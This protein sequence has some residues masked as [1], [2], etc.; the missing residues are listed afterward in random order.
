ME[1]SVLTYWDG[2]LRRICLWKT[3]LV[4]S[5][6]GE[7]NC[8]NIQTLISHHLDSHV[9]LFSG[10]MP[11]FARFKNQP[12]WLPCPALSLQCPEDHV[13]VI[14][15]PTE[16]HSDLPQHIL[17]LNHISSQCSHPVQTVFSLAI[18]TSST[19]FHGAMFKCDC[20]SILSA[21]VCLCLS[22]CMYLCMCLSLCVSVCL[23]V[24]IKRQLVEVSSFLLVSGC[25][26]QVIRIGGQNLY[27]VAILPNVT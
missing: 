2:V 15:S 23:C 9:C 19:W 13:M 25:W 3:H 27:S 18:L 21:S 16:S 24:C 5:S 26:I 22:V 12:T 4:R 14:T 1:G 10:L 11:D 6:C 8:P 7:E 17:Y 20:L